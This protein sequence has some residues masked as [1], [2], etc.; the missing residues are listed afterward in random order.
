MCGSIRKKPTSFH[1]KGRFSLQYF[2]Y[3]KMNLW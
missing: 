1:K 3:F 2:N